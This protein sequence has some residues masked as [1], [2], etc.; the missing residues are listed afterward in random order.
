LSFVLPTLSLKSISI[1]RLLVDLVIF[2]VNGI[3]PSP[4]LVAFICSLM[5]LS[6]QSGDKSSRDPGGRSR[7]IR[8]RS[9]S[10]SAAAIFFTL[11]QRKTQLRTN[12]IRAIW[13]RGRWN[14]GMPRARNDSTEGWKWPI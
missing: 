3:Y 2:P 1:S 6:N 12:H 10:I 13:I 7:S 8:Y 14:G 9:L 5:A 11:L 4:C